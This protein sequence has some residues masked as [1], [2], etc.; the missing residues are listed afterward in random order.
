MLDQIRIRGIRR[1]IAAGRTF[2][3][4]KPALRAFLGAALRKVRRRGW[5]FSPSPLL[6]VRRILDAAV[7]LRLQADDW[8]KSLDRAPLLSRAGLEAALSA[9]A[10]LA[11]TIVSVSHDDYVTNFGGIQNVIADEQRAFEAA[12]WRYL[13]LSPAVPLPILADHGPAADYRLRLRLNGKPLGIVAFPDLA[14]AVA[15]LR[16]N[17]TRVQIVFHHLKGHVPELLAILPIAADV[18]PIA[19]VHDFFTLCPNFSL[20]RNEVKFCGAPPLGSAACTVCVFGGDREEHAPRMRSFFEMLDP[21]ILAPS[22]VTLDFWRRRAGLPHA[23]GMVVP[24]ARLV[25]AVDGAPIAPQANSPLRVA[26]LGASI[27]HKGW[28]V[29]EELA[30]KHARDPR[31]KF[32]HLGAAGVPSFKYVRD[33]VRV[34][35]DQRDAMIEAVVRN[36]IDVVIC[37]SLWPE[38]FCFTVHEA[39]AGGAFVVARQA[40]GNVWPAVQANAAA[41][42]CAVEDDASLFQL[43]EGGEIQALVARARR[44]RGTLHPTGDTAEFLLDA[45]LADKGEVY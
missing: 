38:T 31:Y 14:G 21:M 22:A 34:T 1:V 3:A 18:R 20:M 29:F 8:S 6:M 43:F 41:Q 39:L 4:D 35:P 45:E 37:W 40:A 12:G 13:H 17:G 30:I 19:W 7:P 9:E 23:G 28:H 25:M 24:P 27:M 16:G 42:G 44:V 32:Y 15:E 26:H 33:P 5:T 36:R 2:A 10:G 11:G